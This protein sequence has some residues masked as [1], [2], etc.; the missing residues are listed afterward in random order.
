M[1]VLENMYAPTME[2]APDASVSSNPENVSSTSEEVPINPPRNLRLRVKELETRRWLIN[3][4]VV[5][6]TPHQWPKCCKEVSFREDNECEFRQ[7]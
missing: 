7:A 4:K 1:V 2:V 5:I 6:S 3:L